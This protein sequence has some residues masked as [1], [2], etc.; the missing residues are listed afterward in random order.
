[1]TWKNN[2]I[3]LPPVNI[4]EFFKAISG[5]LPNFGLFF[6]S[7]WLSSLASLQRLL[8]LLLGELLCVCLSFCVCVCVC[9]YLS[10]H[11]PLTFSSLLIFP[12]FSFFLSSSSPSYSLSSHFSPFLSL[13]F[14]FFSF[15]SF[16]PLYFS[17][18]LA[19]PLPLSSYL[20][21]LLFSYSLASLLTS[22]G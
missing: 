1:M 22:P 3:S 9:L 7:S 13:Y 2:H 8:N 17:T 12:S 10:F 19:S 15:F 21:S 11:V 20:T 14:I 5:E 4:Y 6:F 16:L 18:P